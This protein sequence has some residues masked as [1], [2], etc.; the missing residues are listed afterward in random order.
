[1]EGIV[2]TMLPGASIEVDRGAVYVPVDILWRGSY[3]SEVYDD[4]A[5]PSGSGFRPNAISFQFQ[6]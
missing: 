5:L 6:F 3:E 1:M 2:S 4:A